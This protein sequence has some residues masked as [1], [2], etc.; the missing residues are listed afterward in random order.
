M[1]KTRT[2]RKDNGYSTIVATT[3]CGQHY[4][5]NTEDIQYGSGKA[6]RIRKATAHAVRNHRCEETRL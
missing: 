2:V 1:T 3:C 5:V 4:Y 6:E